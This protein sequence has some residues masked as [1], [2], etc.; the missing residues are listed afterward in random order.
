VPWQHHL[1]AHPTPATAV[2]RSIHS[3]RQCVSS[4]ALLFFH[5][6]TLTCLRSLLVA[7]L[8][9]HADTLFF[10]SVAVVSIASLNL[11]LLVNPVG[12]YQVGPRG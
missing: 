7:C 12:L 8:C 1:L 10:S 11:S 9:C 3:S 6:T 4:C 5:R 2:K